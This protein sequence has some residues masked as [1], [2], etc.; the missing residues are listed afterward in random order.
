MIYGYGN[1]DWLQMTTKQRDHIFEN[2]LPTTM[3][4][5]K[6]KLYITETH[7]FIIR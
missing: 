5:N 7:D 6:Y 1:G 2:V 4:N 3:R